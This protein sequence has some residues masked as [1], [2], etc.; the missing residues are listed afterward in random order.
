MK[1]TVN[2]LQKL[3]WHELTGKEK[4][5]LLL[6]EGYEQ[7]LYTALNGCDLTLE[8]LLKQHPDLTPLCHELCKDKTP[9]GCTPEDKAICLLNIAVNLTPPSQ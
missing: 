8:D 4:T 3:K 2:D 1:K 5:I 9:Q 7:R 6:K